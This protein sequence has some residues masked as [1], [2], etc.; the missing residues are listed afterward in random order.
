MKTILMSVAILLVPAFAFAEP[1]PKVVRLWK[2]KC[3]SCH[4]ADGKAQSEQGKKMHMHDITTAAWQKSFTDPQIKEVIEKGVDAQKDGVHKQM[5]PY[6]EKLKPEQ[7]DQL[8]L[9]SR[10][11]QPLVAGR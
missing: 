1:D 2:A 7:I 11:G 3:A 5:D 10:A 8:D 6:K 9:L 4:G